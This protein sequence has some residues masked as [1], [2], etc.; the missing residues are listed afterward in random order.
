MQD[1]IRGTSEPPKE[2]H[3]GGRAPPHAYNGGN[4]ETP[5]HQY[6]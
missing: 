2:K 5:C 3:L 6:A 1:I 4:I